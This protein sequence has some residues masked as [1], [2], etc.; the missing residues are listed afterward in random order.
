[1]AKTRSGL[2]SASIKNLITNEEVFCMFNPEQYTIKKSNSWGGNDKPQMGR[3]VPRV[4]FKSGSAATLD[5]TLIFDSQME[6]KDV[7][8]FTNPLFKMMLIDSSTR[9]ADTN[10]G[11]PPAVA[12]S[13]GK[14]Y[15]K[16]VITSLTQKFT[17]FDE[18]G[19][20]IRCEVQINLQQYADPSENDD[21]V[22]GMAP[23]VTLTGTATFTEGQRLDNIL[24]KG[25]PNP[26][27]LAELNNIDNP[28]AIRNGTSIRR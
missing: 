22:P 8:L 9:D 14:L 12:F 19:M 11:N 21:Q 18:T 2:Q 20:P 5:L 7:R 1:M 3:N 10:K 17:L 25:K 4:E 27:G 16:A 26:R 23:G 15:F 13:W 6:R 24:V 28:L